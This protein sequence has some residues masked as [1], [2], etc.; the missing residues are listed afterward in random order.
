MDIYRAFSLL[1][2]FYFLSGCQPA[3]KPLPATSIE[4]LTLSSDLVIVGKV[5]QNHSRWVDGH[6]ITTSDI[7][8]L[9]TMKGRTGGA[10]LQASFY[11]GTV[12]N[13]NEHVEHEAVLEEG[14]I[15]VLFLKQFK[16]KSDSSPPALS[17]VSE[18]GNITLIQP[19]Q[20]E[21]R[22]TNNRRLI[23]QLEDISIRVQTAGGVR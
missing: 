4:A 21:S 9:Q 16:R 11:G 18:H 1:A 19:W 3:T 20:R 13:I 5:L 10:I 14:Q 12:G 2:F 8:P 23:R 7:Q 22:L 17:I 6:I 15:S